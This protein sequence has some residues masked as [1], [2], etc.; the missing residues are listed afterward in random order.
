MLGAGTGSELAGSACTGRAL[1]RAWTACGPAIEDRFAALQ[2]WSGPR[3]GR[4]RRHE[5]RLV[6]RTRPGLGHHH[7][8]LRLHGGLAVATARRGLRRGRVNGRS[9]TAGE[10]WR[11]SNLRFC[12]GRF[13]NRG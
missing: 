7:A 11:F 2:A 9:D 3:C 6:D 4:S 13:K 8:A 5:G 1:S 12:C 10:G